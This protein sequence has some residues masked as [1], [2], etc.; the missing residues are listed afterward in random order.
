MKGKGKA[1]NGS[2]HKD[3]SHGLQDIAY[4]SDISFF[5]IKEVSTC[6]EKKLQELFIHLKGFKNIAE[7]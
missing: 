4:E 2:Y 3:N 7:I 5:Y 1:V 6:T